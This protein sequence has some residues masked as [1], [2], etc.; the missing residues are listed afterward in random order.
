MKQKMAVVG[1]G[2]A[3]LALCMELLDRG[4]EVDLYD[5]QGIGAGA[6]GV[7]SG[8][9]HPYPGEGVKR[10]AHAEAALAET[11]RLL[12]IAQAHSVEKVYDSSFLIRYATQEQS[13]VLRKHAQVYG[14]V[15]EQEEGKF[16]LTS[17]FSV[18][19]MP[20]LWGLFAAC[21]KKGLRYYVANIASLEQLSGY[22]G[23]VL[24]IGGGVFFSSLCSHSS[25]RAVKGQA[26]VC[27]PPPTLPSHSLLGKGHIV[28]LPSGLVHLGS[29]YERGVIDPSPQYEVAQQDLFS[30]AQ[31][32]YP[33]WDSIVVKQ[34]RA[35]VR[36]ARVGSYLP[37][38]IEI[39]PTIWQLTGLGSRG[40]L[41]HAWAAKQLVTMAGW[42]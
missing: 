32:L 10:S 9:V 15:V 42:L 41:Y 29:T 25:L 2:L 39:A 16:W 37:A 34:V 23:S 19:C 18:F 8:L 30:K 14:D 20:Y 5:A 40:L 4:Y 26:F 17:G 11:K 31:A 12:E 35:G 21:Q 1:A 27:D 6:S 7:A 38:C 33:S 3:G 36:V 24:A 22:A 28:P 13:L